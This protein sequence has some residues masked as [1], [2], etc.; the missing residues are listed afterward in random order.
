MESSSSCLIWDRLLSPMASSPLLQKKQ[1]FHT[2][3]HVYRIPALIYLAQHRTFLA[4]A[5]QRASTADE[6]AKEIVLRRGEYKPSANLVQWQEMT[7]MRTAQLQGHRSMN[8]SPVYDETTGTLFLLFIVVPGQVSEQHQITT[9]T[10]MARLCYVS[11]QDQGRTWSPATDLTNSAIGPAYKEW[12]TFGIGPGHGVQLSNSSRRLVIPAYAYRILKP[13][14]KPSPFAFCFLSDDHGQTWKMGN[15]T[16]MENTLESQVV[17]VGVHGQRVLYCN[18]RS[19]HKLRVQAVSFNDGMD[20]LDAQ[21]NPTLV[22]PP[23]GCHGSV[24]GFPDPTQ[25]VSDS[26]DTWVLY[27]HPT[28][29]SEREDLGIYLNRNPLDPK[30]WTKPAILA[31]GLC[32]YSDLQYMGPGPNG[33]PQFGCLFEYGNYNEIL[34]FMFTLEQVFHS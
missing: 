15:F 18:S 19:T 27:S 11:S 13:H 16:T 3:A 20:F 24:V 1:L 14:K 30:G 26:A 5:E 17:E 10:N 8:P 32:A 21:L 25:N 29:P 4:F 34:F 31:R 6:K 9:K 7:V 33:S 23:H 2:G 12:A 22:E 28:N